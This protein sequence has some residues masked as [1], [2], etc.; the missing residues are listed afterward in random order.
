MCA[1]SLA[2]PSTEQ[3]EETDP[4]LLQRT[5][6]CRTTS[7]MINPSFIRPKVGDNPWLLDKGIEK[8][9]RRVHT[10]SLLVSH[11]KKTPDPVL[12]LVGEWESV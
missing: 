11:V 5:S 6:K 7:G 8:L 1:P 12:S 2:I 9:Q 10:P 3:T 4:S